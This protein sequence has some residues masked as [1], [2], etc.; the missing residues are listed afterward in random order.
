MNNIQ[1]HASKLA[2]LAL[3]VSMST[4]AFAQSAGS[5]GST[6]GSDGGAA[7]SGSSGT[8]SGGVTSSSGTFQQWLNAQQG[9]RITRKAYMDE[10]GRRW[11]AMDHSSQGLTYDE[12]NRTYGSANMGGQTANTPQQRSGMQK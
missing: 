2:L 12:I 9:K 3:A 7:A 4:G 5:A 6:G 11:D 10:V 1:K 8:G